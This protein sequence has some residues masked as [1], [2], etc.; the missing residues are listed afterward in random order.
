MSVSQQKL[1]NDAGGNRNQYIVA[2]GL[3]PMVTA[4]RGTQVV[5]A[6]VIDHILPVAVFDRKALAPVECVV[7]TCATLVPSLVPVTV[8][9]IPLVAVLCLFIAIAIVVIPIAVGKGKSPRGQRY[10]DDGGN[11]C[12]NLHAELHLIAFD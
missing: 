7:W 5:A 8:V 10:C 12:F 11:N 1:Q 9:A 3:N 6:P 4:R 2:A